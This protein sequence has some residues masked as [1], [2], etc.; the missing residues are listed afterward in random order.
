MLLAVATA[1]WGCC[2]R[3]PYLFIMFGSPH[4]LAQFYISQ[5]VTDSY[6]HV[7]VLKPLI[8]HLQLN[9]A[10]KLLLPEHLAPR[11]DRLQCKRRDKQLLSACHLRC[12]C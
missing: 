1:E 2:T 5:S 6:V 11:K 12:Q 3:S 4:G 8:F 7:T 10:L 9:S